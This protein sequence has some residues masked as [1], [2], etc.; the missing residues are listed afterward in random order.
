M[1]DHLNDMDVPRDGLVA[2]GECKCLRPATP[3]RLAHR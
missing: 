1:R 2:L 3:R